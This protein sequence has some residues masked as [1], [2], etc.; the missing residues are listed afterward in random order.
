MNQVD[1]LIPTCKDDWEL[2]EQIGELLQSDRD[3][4]G[5]RIIYSCQKAS[6][7]VNRNYCLNLAHSEIVVMIDDDMA[8][9]FPGWYNLLVAPLIA[10]KDVIQVSARL[11]NEDG[12]IGP[13]MGDMKNYTQPLVEVPLVPSACIAFRNDGTRFYEGYKGSGYEDSDFIFQLKDK[14]PNGKILV[15]NECRL[16]HK[17]EMKNQSKHFEYNKAIFERRFPNA[18]FTL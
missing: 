4:D 5:D 10:D 8:G 14:Y 17:H 15:S 1:I 7:S 9:F 3:L 13:M 16:I 18:R 6:A 12:S 11:L 2:C